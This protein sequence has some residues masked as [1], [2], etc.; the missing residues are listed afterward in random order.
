MCVAGRSEGEVGFFG[1]VNKMERG[2]AEDGMETGNL[3]KRLIEC[4]AVKR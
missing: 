2:G 3:R 4:C 1:R